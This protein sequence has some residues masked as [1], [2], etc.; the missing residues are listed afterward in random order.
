MRGQ[1]QLGGDGQDGGRSGG[2]RGVESEQA[3]NKDEAVGGGA[4][5]ARHET[6]LR[7]AAM[8]HK[9]GR[10]NVSINDD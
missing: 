10:K 7:A 2:R 3:A 5:L 6:E 9:C 1:S 8:S 4:D